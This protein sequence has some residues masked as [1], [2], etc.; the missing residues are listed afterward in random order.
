MSKN[1]NHFITPM[2]S[3]GR[4]MDSIWQGCFVSALSWPWF[5]WE[6]SSRL[7]PGS[8]RS[9]LHSQKWCLGFAGTFRP[10]RWHMAFPVAWASSQN[11][12][13][14]EVMRSSGSRGP[15][16]QGT[17]QKLYSLLWPSLGSQGAPL[18]PFSLGQRSHKPTQSQDRRAQKP[19][20]WW[21]EGQEIC[22]YFKELPQY[23]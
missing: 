11:G 21:E 22:G 23:Q 7:G 9:R 6:D 14:K 13:L 18:L 4:E 16:L 12:G 20:S 15:V 10:E 1:K 17:R 2:D 8:I 19:T 5:S 3:M